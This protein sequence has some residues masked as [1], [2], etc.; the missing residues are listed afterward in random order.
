[1]NED[2]MPE[3]KYKVRDTHFPIS[4]FFVTLIML[5]LVGAAH[6]GLVVQINAHH[7]NGY[8]AVFIIILYWVA[9]SVGYTLYTRRQIRNTYEKPMKEIAQ[10][11]NQVANGDFSVYLSPIHT[12]ENMDYLDVLIMDFNK[13]VEELGSIETLK[14]DFFSSVSHEIKTP[15][16]VMLNTAELLQNSEL[17]EKQKENVM[18]MIWSG[19]KLSA[20]ITNILKI[21][22]LE[23]QNIQPIMEEYDLCEQLCQSALQYEAVWEEKQLEF[24]VDMEDRVSI[25]AD[26]SLLE[27]VWTNLLSNAIKFTSPG[28]KI[29]LKQTS[30]EHEIIVSVSDTGCGMS[31]ETIRHIFDKFYQG[32]T[33]RSVEGNGLGLAL[34]F[35]IVQIMG[36]TITVESE[37]EK[38]STFTV[39]LPVNTK[40]G[41]DK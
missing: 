20:L 24:E 22:K 7:L 1:M 32:D 12:K 16:A 30:T 34:A 38:G 21:N 6:A 36:G 10:A 4:L 41:N 14:T 11:A 23:K 27:L 5:L 8:L 29:S 40:G 19:R 15:L 31:K 28:G 33:S 17:D 25:E 37:P 2:R 13:M 39:T 26:A 35:R 9:V 3:Q 18:T